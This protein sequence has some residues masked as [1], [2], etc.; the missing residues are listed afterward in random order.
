M[1]RVANR[2]HKPRV[3]DESHDTDC[4]YCTVSEGAVHRY[5]CPVELTPAK[6][7]DALKSWHA[8]HAAALNDTI[9]AYNIDPSYRLGATI[10]FQGGV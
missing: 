7:A 9:N 1:T 2:A 3:A 5:G 8:G 6:Q 4:A 10:G